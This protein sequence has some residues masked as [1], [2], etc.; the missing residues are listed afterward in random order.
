MNEK[1]DRQ[2]QII[3]LILIG[4]A[5][6]C[7]PWV[8]AASAP[9]GLLAVVERVPFRWVGMGVISLLHGVGFVAVIC[10]AF[11]LSERGK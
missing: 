10:F 5:A 8:R 1:E 3:L 11:W 7:W 2:N 6:A 9:D 4:L